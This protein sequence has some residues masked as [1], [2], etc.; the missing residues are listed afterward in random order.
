MPS[1]ASA[2]TRVSRP[3]TSN[4]GNRCSA[5][6]AACAPN[7]GEMSGSLYSS[8][9]SATALSVTLNTPSTLVRPEKKNPAPKWQVNSRQFLRSGMAV[10]NL[11]RG[12][13][14]GRE[15][16]RHQLLEIGGGI[17]GECIQ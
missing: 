7:S 2:D 6:A 9:N 16:P 8:A 3:A 5:Y 11:N 17:R 10:V 14:A 1:S 12:K 13:G 4:S 15:K